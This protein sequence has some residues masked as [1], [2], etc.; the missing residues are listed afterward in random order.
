MSDAEKGHNLTNA[1]IRR[2]YL[3]QVSR[4]PEL[5]REWI[6]QGLS[7]EERAAAAWRIRHE[8][9]LQA[10]S[11]MANRAEVELLRARDAAEYGDPDGPTFEFLCEQA[12]RAGMEDEA[13][14]QSIIDGSYRTNAGV[15]RGLGLEG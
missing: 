8:A 7:P 12:R 6:G 15:S 10:R 9:R 4:I 2:W 13:I 14:Y 11:M 1:E 5:N 3:E